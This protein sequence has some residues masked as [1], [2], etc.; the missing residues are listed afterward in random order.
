MNW[1]L[2]I[3]TQVFF[4]INH[5]PHVGRIDSFALFLSGLGEAG[6]IWFILG[7][8]LVYREETKDHRLFLPLAVAAGFT[9]SISELILKPLVGRLRPSSALDAATVVGG[10]PLGYS[11]PSTHTAFAFAL[12]VILSYK[13]PKWKKWLLAL[14]CTIG[15]SRIYLGHHYPIDV[16]FG[17]L[18]GWGIGTLVVRWYKEISSKKRYNKKNETKRKRASNTSRRRRGRKSN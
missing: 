12:A 9:W 3:D 13:E 2:S 18:I 8:V 16:I 11:F 15:L 14:A 6:I 17:G 4:F 10:F 5:L 1:L 7:A